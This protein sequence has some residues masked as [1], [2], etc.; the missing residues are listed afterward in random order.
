MS[1]RRVPGGAQLEF[2][3]APGNVQR[4][5]YMAFAVFVRLA[6]I[7]QHIRCLNRRLG[8]SERYFLDVAPGLFDEFVCVLHPAFSLMLAK[9]SRG[10]S[11]A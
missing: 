4:T 9:R 10:R 7:D 2:Q 11:S 1:A 6:D 8:V 3:N 5:V